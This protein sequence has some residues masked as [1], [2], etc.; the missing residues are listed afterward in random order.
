M[1]ERIRHVGWWYWMATDA[2]LAAW[3]FAGEPGALGTAILLGVI[4]STHYWLREGDVLAFPVQVR[5]V[6]LGL[7]CLGATDTF[8]FLHWIQLVGT[9]ALLVFD[10]CPLARMLSLAP[11]N[12]SLPFSWRLLWHTIVSAPVAGRIKV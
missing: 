9:T 5:I 12:R 7:L 8:R 3:L 2:L 6:Y 1:N 11:W 10:Y 4:Q